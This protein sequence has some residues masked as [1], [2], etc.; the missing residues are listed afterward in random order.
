MFT[1]TVD[2]EIP[3]R[4]GTAY[5]FVWVALL[6]YLWSIW[7]RLGK[8]DQELSALTRRLADKGGAGQQR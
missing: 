4:E 8:V 5:A 7:R 6:A 3:P 2:A 1:Y